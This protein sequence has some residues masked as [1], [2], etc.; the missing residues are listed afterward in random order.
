MRPIR[1]NVIVS[2]ITPK[3]TT[4]SGIILKSNLEV[5]Q[6]LVESIGEDITEVSVGDRVVLDWGKTKDLQDN[7]YLISIN[8]IA[9]VLE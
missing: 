8:D 6:A 4:E 3:L 1:N 7:L 2:R 5:D 9:L